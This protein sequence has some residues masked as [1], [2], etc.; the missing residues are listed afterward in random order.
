VSAQVLLEQLSLQGAA[1]QFLPLSD[2]ET[3]YQLM[4]NPDVS[5]RSRGVME[6]CNT[7]KSVGKITEIEGRGCATARS[8]P[9]SGSLSDGSDCV[10]QHQRSQQP[11]GE[12]KAESRTI[13]CWES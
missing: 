6:K 11:R 7:Q 3:T 8:S 5:I 10:W 12:A 9:L 13:H 2:W 1:L 4:R